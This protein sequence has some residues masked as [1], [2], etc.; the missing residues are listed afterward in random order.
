MRM[1]RICELLLLRVYN[2]KMTILQ[3]II[4]GIVEGITEFLPVSSTAHLIIISKFLRL[5]QTD[6]QKFFEVFIQSGAIFAVV[7]LYFNYILKNTKLISKLLI[8]FFPT[9]IVG[10]LLY[11]IIKNIFFESFILII[12]ALIIVGLLFIF[13]EYL[14]K[15]KKV[16]LQKNINYLTT[17]EAILVGLVQSIAVIPGVS[18]SGIVMLIMMVRGY[19]RDQAAQYS[20]LLAAPTIFAA[21]LY[22]FFKMRSIFAT[23]TQYLPLL[24]IGFIAS[25]IVAYIVMKWFINYLQN[26]SLFYFGIYRIG[27]AIILLISR[28]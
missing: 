22:D 14:I 6:F 27:L 24:L 3:S 13:I 25:F 17:F 10:F 15:N 9:A 7:L 19:K 20:F 8:S 18:R 28:P 26:N 12:F 23:S 16:R 2:L 11:K 1:M 21:S 4:L 5:P